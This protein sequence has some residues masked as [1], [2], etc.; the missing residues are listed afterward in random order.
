MLKKKKLQEKKEIQKQHSMLISKLTFKNIITDT[1]HSDKGENIP[2]LS[3]F[4]AAVTE[5]LKL[6]RNVLT[7]DSGG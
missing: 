4:C 5:Y 3:P 7:H 2:C 6:N 1:C